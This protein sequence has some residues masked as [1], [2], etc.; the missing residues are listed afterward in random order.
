MIAELYWIDGP[1]A[2]RL[3]I[4]PRPRGGDW[5]NVDL[6]A[7]R[8]WHVDTVLSLLETN[9][10][11]QLDLTA[12]PD[13]CSVY[14]IE[15]LNFPIEDRGVPPSLLP[16]I[17]LLQELD[18]RLASGQRVLVHCRQGV[19]RSGMIASGLLVLRGFKVQEAVEVVSKARGVLVPETKEQLAWLSDLSASA[20]AMRLAG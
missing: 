8:G 4:A 3:A 13:A 18:R 5:L 15:Y 20:G 14:N 17:N 2:G 12:E 6:A 19:G 11:L 7:W 1:W 9:E 10:A 16:G